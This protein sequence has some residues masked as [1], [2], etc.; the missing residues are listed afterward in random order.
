MPRPTDPADVVNIALADGRHLTV[1]AV[2]ATRVRGVD[3][4]GDLLVTLGEPDHPIRRDDGA[5]YLIPLT[6]CCHA[7]GKGA[8]SATGVVCRGCYREVDPKYGRPGSHA[9]AIARA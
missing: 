7:D 9:I 1:H 8:E 2:F 5:E 3:A 6:P 4:D